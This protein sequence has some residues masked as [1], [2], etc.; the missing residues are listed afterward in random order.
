MPTTVIPINSTTLNYQNIS[1]DDTVLL[2][3][4]DITS[5]F[6]PTRDIVEYFIYDIDKNL[7]LNNNNYTLAQLGLKY[8]CTQRTIKYWLCK[9][10]ISIYI[11]FYFG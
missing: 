1:S 3:S 8:N 9:W 4:L 2:G 10:G 5:L 6:D 11:S 7:L